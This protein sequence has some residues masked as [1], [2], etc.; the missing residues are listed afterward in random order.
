[1]GKRGKNKPRTR[2][3]NERVSN[4]ADPPNRFHYD[5]RESCSH[6]VTRWRRCAECRIEEM[7]RKPS[8]RYWPKRRRMH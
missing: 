2:I 4:P 5:V 1:M 8:M 7:N 6:G 3:V